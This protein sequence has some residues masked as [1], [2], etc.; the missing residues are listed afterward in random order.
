MSKSVRLTDAFEEYLEVLRLQGRSPNTIRSRQYLLRQLMQITGDM[1]LRSLN[2]RHVD[3]FFQAHPDWSLSS[4]KKMV[5]YLSAF[6][7]WAQQRR[8]MPQGD[9]LLHMRGIKVP[10]RNRLRLPAE[11]FP[12]LLNA[13][14]ND[15]DRVIIALG[16][17]LFLRASEIAHLRWHHV[18]LDTGEI[19]V[20]RDKTDEWD[21]MPI[22][23]ELEVELKRWRRTVTESLGVPQPEWYVAPGYHQNVVERDPHT[24]Q[25]VRAHGQLDPTKKM[26]RPYEPVKLALRKLGYDTDAEGVHTLRRSGAR[27]LYDY[28]AEQGHDG[29]VRQAQAMLG[30]ASLTTTET[31]LG[32]SLDRKRR[33]DRLKGRPMFAATEA[34]VIPLG[35]RG[36]GGDHAV[37][38]DMGG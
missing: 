22:C 3:M 34:E 37:R 15:R 23:T 11:K 20:W 8:Y 5:D 25:I 27:A 4:R 26:R 9:L 32:V 36:S 16:C 18:D 6:F 2:E 7:G 38:A 29:A 31:Y 13:A 35:G 10:K 21:P 14:S 17:Y 28:L 12:E 24:G 19:Q 30:H 33:N 1:Y